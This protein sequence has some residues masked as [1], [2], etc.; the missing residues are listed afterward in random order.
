MGFIETLREKAVN[1]RTKYKIILPESTD[2][3]VLKAASQL[4]AQ[5]IAVPVLIGK[6]E[7]I[8][9]IAAK[10]GIKL[11]G[12]EF[13][14]PSN[15]PKTEKLAEAFFE[16]R[17]Q[18]GITIEQ[19]RETI[20]SSPT[21]LAALLINEGMYHSFVSG[22]ISTSADVAKAAIYCIG[23]DEKSGALSSSF[24]IEIPNCKYG[25]NGLFVFADCG[26]IPNP[27]PR[28]LAGIAY[29]S[30]KLFESLVGKKAKVAMLSFS[31]KGS[32]EGPMVEKVREA[33]NIAK[34]LYPDM[35]IDGELQ[36]DAAVDK[37]VA[38]KKC[39]GSPVAGEANVLVFPDLNAGNIGYKLANRLAG[40]R[41]VGPL[42]QGLKVP[43]SDLSRG[44][45][46]DD[47]IDAAAI[48]SIRL[49]A[50]G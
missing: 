23:I 49:N 3:R 29:A 17:K 4:V 6:K 8:E 46:A 50:K 25:E 15:N 21:Y 34:E 26:I 10:D 31:T 36:L 30:A 47:I 18:K 37:D 42:L 27:P 16:I 19:A 48:V 12:V 41:A 13:F 35:L 5:N 20:I 14:N 1:N 24:L 43:C 39:K 44:C 22:A 38:A 33:T 9:K 7:E 2:L 45:T 32:A 40:G 28:K 11:T